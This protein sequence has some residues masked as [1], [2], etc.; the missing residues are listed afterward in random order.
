MPVSACVVSKDL[1]VFIVNCRADA[2]IE[3]IERA[4]VLVLR[5]RIDADSPTLET[6]PVHVTGKAL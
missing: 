3:D 4:M 5:S 6:L 2:R 1:P